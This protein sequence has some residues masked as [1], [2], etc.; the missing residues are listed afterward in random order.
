M[1]IL[2]CKNLAKANEKRDT[3]D[4]Y[5]KAYLLPDKSRG[6]KKKTKIKKAMLN[7]VCHICSNHIASHSLLTGASSESE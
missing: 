5:V 4:P 1:R 2:C 6:G 3:S 7:P